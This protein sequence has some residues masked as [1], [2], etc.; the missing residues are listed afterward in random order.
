MNTRNYQ[1]GICGV[2]CG[3]CPNG[4]GRVKMMAGELK[5]LVDTVRYNW[6]KDVVKSFD[7]DEFRKGLE[8]L[9]DSQ[10][11]SCLNG[12]GAPCENR[13]CASRKSLQSCL[14]CDDYLTC[15][16]TE[17]QRDVYPFVVDN[18]NRVKQV[19]FEKHLEEEEERTKAGIDLMG[20]L[21]RR[22]CKVVK[23]EDK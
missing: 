10:C 16:N 4:N 13:K 23:L 14:L 20:H 21:E 11:P 3:Q 6:V 8:W 9:S 17:Y 2:Y 5:R 1:Y 15:K 12:G 18:Y 19:G 22:C 7:F